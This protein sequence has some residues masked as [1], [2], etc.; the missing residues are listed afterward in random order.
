[1]KQEVRQIVNEIIELLESKELPDFC[2]NENKCRKCG[3]KQT[4]YN[5]EEVNSLLKIKI[6]SRI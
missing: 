5:E 6:S 2:D 1:M 4:C 3:L